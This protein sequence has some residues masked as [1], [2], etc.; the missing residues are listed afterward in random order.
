MRHIKN[1][2][3]MSEEGLLIALLK[4]G[5]VLLT[6]ITKNMKA[7]ETKYKTLSSKEYLDMIRPYLRDMVNYYK[8]PLK[9]KVHSG[10]KITDCKNQFGSEWKIQL[11]M[12]I[13]FISSKGSEEICT[14]STK[15]DNIEIVIGNKTDDVIKELC[16]SLLER[17]QEGLEEKM[18]G[19][20]FVCDSI[21]L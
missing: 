11:T 8:A 2:K 1:Y 3:N 10:N 20:D 5:W 14:I 6:V 19:S 17:Y 21:D 7:K 18:K 13:N 16:E 9:L 12:Q 15:I 4:S